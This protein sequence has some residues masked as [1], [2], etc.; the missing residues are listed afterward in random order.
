MYKWCCVKA[1]RG[2]GGAKPTSGHFG[3]L[4]PIT[5]MNLTQIALMSESVSLSFISRDFN[6]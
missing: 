1:L 6:F 2:C 5:P 3:Q 4:K